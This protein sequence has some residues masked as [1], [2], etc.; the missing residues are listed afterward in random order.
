MMSM[1][2]IIFSLLTLIL[3]VSLFGQ[4][5]KNYKIRSYFAFDIPETMELRDTP[6]VGGQQ[7]CFWPGA[8][9][10][11]YAR[12]LVQIGENPGISQSD[13]VNLS[14]LERQEI[15]SLFL[16]EIRRSGMSPSQ[17]KIH[18]ND[19]RKVGGKYAIVKKYTRPG[20]NGDVYVEAYDYFVGTVHIQVTMSYRTSES[21][22]WKA[23]FDKVIQSISWYI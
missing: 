16:D 21:S 9:S 11:K 10:T 5:T 17:I 14:P 19:V 20:L 12:I 1:K 7:Y 3:S 13:L 4:S 15:K 18:E 2:K 8:S 23:D 22:Y 6:G